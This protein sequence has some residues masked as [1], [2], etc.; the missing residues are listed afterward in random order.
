MLSFEPIYIYSSCA[1][2]CRITELD[3]S[4]LEL[5]SVTTAKNAEVDNLTAELASARGSLEHAVDVKSSSDKEITAL[6]AGLPNISF[7]YYHN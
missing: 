5:Q 3:A 4:V 1:I 6:K 2:V 7:H